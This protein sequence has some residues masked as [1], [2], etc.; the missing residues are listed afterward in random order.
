MKKIIFSALMCV[1]TLSASAQNATVNS[2]FCD[3]WFIGIG[4]GVYE[5]TVGQS[6]FSAMRPEVNFE[7]GRYFT[8]EFGIRA[9]LVAGIN[10]NN[11]IG[12][13]GQLGCEMG[14]Q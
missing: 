5:P 8:P 12:N 10:T 4:G 11:A 9:N 6:V 1:A 14:Y 3:N 7:I 2:K 13:I